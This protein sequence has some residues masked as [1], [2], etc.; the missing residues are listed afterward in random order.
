VFAWY[1]APERTLAPLPGILLLHGGHG[2]AYAEWA[3]AWAARGYAA[4][5]LDL[6]G[7]GPE[8]APLQDAGPALA[9]ELVF[10][11]LAEGVEAAWP[12]HAVAAA[13]RGVA[14][15]AAQPEVDPAR[16]CATGISWGAVVGCILAG[17]EPRLRTCV[18]VYGGGY[19]AACSAF[20]PR[21]AG[22]PGDL[23][24]RWS[25]LFDPASYLPHAQ[26]PMLWIN[27]ATDPIFYLDGTL[28]S[29]RATPTP[30]A[31]SLR[32]VMAHGHEAGWAPP[33][34]ALWMDGLLRHGLPLPRL[35]A[36]QAKGRTVQAPLQ[37]GSQILRVR[38]HF[39]TDEGSWSAR[40]WRTAYGEVEEIGDQEM[41]EALLP[42]DDW[43]AC[44][45]SV[46]DDRGAVVSTDV[47]TPGGLA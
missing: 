16:L 22:L 21:L 19:L 20:D 39:S 2:R 9:D 13:L 24:T 44:F 46:L 27:G 3:L 12:Y 31:L 1:A 40:R 8:G 34:I 35:G 6:G 41:A 37:T 11:A 36:P 4:L 29:F 17:L 45:L 15:L 18:P 28:R 32:P 33:E 14:W 30:G 10:E 25:A 26:A 5:A 42:V 47:L 23:G 7:Q 38:A 43:R